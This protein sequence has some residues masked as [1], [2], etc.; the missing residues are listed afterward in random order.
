MDI[1]FGSLGSVMGGV[2]ASMNQGG[3]P[4]VTAPGISTFSFNVGLG[5][6]TI[7]H[8]EIV[9]TPADFLWT[10]HSWDDGLHKVTS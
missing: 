5:L 6:A 3:G 2:A 4:V 1:N 10:V 8:N 7:Q 9:G